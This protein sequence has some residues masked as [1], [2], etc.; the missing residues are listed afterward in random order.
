MVAMR[1]MGRGWRPHPGCRP[2]AAAR[3][4]RPRRLD[5]PN[6]AA[7]RAAP[8]AAQPAASTTVGCEMHPT[9]QPV[10]ATVTPSAPH[11]PQRRRGPMPVPRPTPPRTPRPAPHPAPAARGRSASRRLQEIQARPCNPVRR[12]STRGAAL[13]E[14]F[15][16]G[17]SIRSRRRPSMHSFPATLAIPDRE[18][19]PRNRPHILLRA[20]PA[21]SAAPRPLTGPPP[22]PGD[23]QVRFV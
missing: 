15:P 4:A 5:A 16:A 11:R 7:G 12:A 21:S 10:T 18:V 22:V 9:Q 17:G 2:L 14:R 1:A 13:R 23:P 3:R 19:A 20:P 8:L 6:A